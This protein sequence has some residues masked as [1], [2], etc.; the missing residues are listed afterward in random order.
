[1]QGAD[2]AYIDALD[3]PALGVGI[4]FSLYALARSIDVALGGA[5]S[6]GGG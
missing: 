1:M 3:V 2:V 5:L 6:I 4:G